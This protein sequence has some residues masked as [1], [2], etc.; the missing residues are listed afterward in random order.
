MIKIYLPNEVDMS[1]INDNTWD[2]PIEELDYLLETNPNGK[3]VLF[4]QRL[5][6]IEEA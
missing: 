1:I 4:E 6:E 5:Y 3:Y 2:Y